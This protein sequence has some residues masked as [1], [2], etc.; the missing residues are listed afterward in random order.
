[1]F[2]IPHILRL[3]A[4][5]VVTRKVEP[6]PAAGLLLDGAMLKAA[7][8]GI[9]NGNV[10]LYL[11]ALNDTLLRFDIT[12]P[13]RIA[14]FLAQVGHESMSFSVVV[15]NLNYSAKGLRKIFPKYFPTLE[16][17]NRYA[18]KPQAIANR[19]YANRMGN[20][21]EESGDGWRHRGK[22]LI[23]TT[24]ANNY[25][26]CGQALGHDFI[27][28]PDALAQLP[29]SVLSAGWFWHGRVINAAADDDNLVRATKL[30][31]GGTNGLSDR[32]IRLSIAKKVL[33]AR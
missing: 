1:M 26:M 17:A 15:E 7:V 2:G 11:P 10:A 13:L 32:R 5:R 25:E 3:A 12:S 6:S 29:W 18:R 9:T 16:L 8:P 14:H 31:N 24:G 22:G 23:Q 4:Q 27:A 19:V 21:P 33:G 28:D 20:G 30:V